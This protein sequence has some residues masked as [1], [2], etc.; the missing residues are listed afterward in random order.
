MTTFYLVRHASNDLIGKAIAGRAPGVSLNRHGQREAEKIAVRLAR[1]QIDIIFSS[2]LERAVETAV[3]LAKRCGLDIQIADALN[4]IDYGIWTRQKLE[5]L[6]PLP[7]WQRWN[8]FRSGARVP[9]GETMIEAQARI[10]TEVQRLRAKYPEQTL[11]LFSHGDLVR[12]VLAYFL[13]VPL[14]LFQ[15]IE[16]APASISILQLSEFEPKIVCVNG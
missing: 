4:E 15:R 11:A 3:P 7:G 5:Q 1:K 12:A 13:G 2:P 10:V 16:I 14:D 8:S 9:N 6:D